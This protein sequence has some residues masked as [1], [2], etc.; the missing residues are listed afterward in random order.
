MTYLKNLKAHMWG[1]HGVRGGD[2]AL[3]ER[4]EISRDHLWHGPETWGGRGSQEF[5]VVTLAETP[6]SR[7]IWSLKWPPPVPRQDL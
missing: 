1:E 5:M 2:K 6:N 7:V 3:G 4:I